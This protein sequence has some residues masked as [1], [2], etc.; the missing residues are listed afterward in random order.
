MPRFAARLFFLLDRDLFQRIRVPRQVAGEGHLVRLE[1]VRD[2]VDVLL[3]LQPPGLSSGIV[4]R[5][6]STRLLAL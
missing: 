2:D 5:T 3:A 4:D 6:C 1:D